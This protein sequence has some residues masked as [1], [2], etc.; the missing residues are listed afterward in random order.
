MDQQEI[1]IGSRAGYWL[2]RI[3]Q[4][5]F[6][7]SAIVILVLGMTSFRFDIPSGELARSS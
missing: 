5:V 7:F 4:T 6:I 1:E 2:I 3:V